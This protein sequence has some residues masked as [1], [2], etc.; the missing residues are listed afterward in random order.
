MP[1]GEPHHRLEETPSTNDVARQYAAD[2]AAH[3]TVVSTPHQTAGKGRQGRGWSDVAGAIALSVVVREPVDRLLPLRAGLAVAQLAGPAAKVK[4]PNDVQIDGRKVA[5]V[6]VER[7]GN[8]AIVGIGVNAAIDVTELPEEVSARAGSLGLGLD[9][10]DDTQ[11]RL[12]VLLDE[13]LSLTPAEVVSALAA[14]DALV[15]K[16]VRWDGGSGT[17][18]GIAEDGSLI[19]RL[20]DGTERRLDGGEV[21]LL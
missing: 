8:A 1:I 12:L 21:H 6:L 3:G 13:T 11:D 16:A 17:A 4:W 10:L 20:D 15:G 5:G 14:R 19:V 18:A 7:E 2:G 9:E